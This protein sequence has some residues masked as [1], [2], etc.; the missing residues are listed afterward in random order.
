MVN[1][2]RWST[3]GVSISLQLYIIWAIVWCPN[4]VIDIGEWSICGGGRL[5]RFYCSSLCDDETG[6]YRAPFQSG[7]GFHS[8]VTS[9]CE[10]KRPG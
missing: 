6:T 2:R 4:N 10:H 9:F 7:D 8:T 5:E 3:L 1:L